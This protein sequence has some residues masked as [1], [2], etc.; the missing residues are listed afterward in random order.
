MVHPSL[1]PVY[2]QVRFLPNQHLTLASISTCAVSEKPRSVAKLK[3][4]KPWVVSVKPGNFY[5]ETMGKTTGCYIFGDFNGDKE[6]VGGS[7]KIEIADYVEFQ[8][9]LKSMK[10]GSVARKWLEDL[11][12]TI[13]GWNFVGRH[14]LKFC[15]CTIHSKLII[16]LPPGSSQWKIQ[17]KGFVAFLY[18]GSGPALSKSFSFR[19]KT[20][21]QARHPKKRTSLCGTFNPNETIVKVKMEILSQRW[22]TFNNIPTYILKRPVKSHFMKL[23]FQATYYSYT[24]EN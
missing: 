21:R 10:G 17:M 6:I 19:S 11:L 3:G 16:C 1:C 15:W 18:L 5:P 7:F 12:N 13:D 8:E 22:W 24:P 9:L 20:T 14:L 2:V 4:T 23:T